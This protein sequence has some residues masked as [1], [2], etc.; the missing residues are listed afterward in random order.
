[1]AWRASDWSLP[2]LAKELSSTFSEGDRQ[3]KH[4]V[5]ARYPIGSPEARLTSE[6]KS[7]GFTVTDTSGAMSEARL[8]RFI[9]CGDTVW[10]VAW[11]ASKGK[12]TEVRAFYGAVCL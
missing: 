3:F 9:G 10:G 5:V 1:M 11:S 8:T 2:P 12:L 6:L 4:R 7:Q